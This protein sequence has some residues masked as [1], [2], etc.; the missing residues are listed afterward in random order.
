MSQNNT[1]DDADDWWKVLLSYLDAKQASLWTHSLNYLFKLRANPQILSAVIHSLGIL[2]L[3]LDGVAK[4]CAR[5]IEG[6]QR[7][8]DQSARQNDLLHKN[9]EALNA[10]RAELIKIYQALENMRGKIEK[11]TIPWGK[12]VSIATVSACIAIAIFLNADHLWFLRIPNDQDAQIRRLVEENDQLSRDL[13]KE[14]DLITNLRY[15]VEHQSE[16]SELVGRQQFIR[17]YRQALEEIQ[18][19]Q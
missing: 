5:M 10:N 3:V 17:G 11:A 16:G 4:Q 1:K 13:A 15:T 12:A 19:G 6:L 2:G 7:A 9:T 8:S 14:H 18:K